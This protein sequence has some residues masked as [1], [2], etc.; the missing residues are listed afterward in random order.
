MYLMLTHKR[1]DDY[2]VATGESNTV[3]DFANAAM[4]YLGLKYEWVGTGLQEYCLDRKT[5]KSI[6]DID[7]LLYRPLE[8]RVTRGNFEKARRELNWQPR[9]DFKSLVALMVD[10]EK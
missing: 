8:V 4:D 1:A 9:I 2:V 7:P 3:R 5:G 6:I 10:A